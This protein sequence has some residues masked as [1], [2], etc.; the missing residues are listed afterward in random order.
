M[1]KEKGKGI[2][3]RDKS[4]YL[5]TFGEVD[6]ATLCNG[7]EAEA[8]EAGLDRQGSG[9]TLGGMQFAL[10]SSVSILGSNI[11]P[12]PLPSDRRLVYP[13]ELFLSM[14]AHSRKERVAILC[15]H[16]CTRACSHWGLGGRRD[17]LAVWERGLGVRGSRFMSRFLH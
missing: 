15:F 13:L 8:G 10:P 3:A 17:S 6:A 7:E 2:E 14:H 4:A 9:A 12:T 1:G 5:G 11:A 16:Q